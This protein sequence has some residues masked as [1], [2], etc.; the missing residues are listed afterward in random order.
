M[1]I[2]NPWITLVRFVYFIVAG[3]GDFVFSRYIVERC[4]DS[5]ESKF[6]KSLEPVVGV[7]VF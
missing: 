4:L 1:V 5:F 7:F 2:V 6:F 3:F